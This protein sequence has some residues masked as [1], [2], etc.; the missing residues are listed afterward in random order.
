VKFAGARERDVR[1]MLFLPSF[2]TVEYADATQ[3]SVQARS[4]L[5]R[6]LIVQTT[7]AAQ[8]LE[9]GVRRVLADADP[10]IN[11]LRVLPLTLQVTGNFRI[12]RLVA[13]LLTIYG[14]LALALALLGLYGVTA[15]GVS[16]R[17]REIGVRMALGADRRGVVQTCVRGP[18]IQTA[19]GLAIGLVGAVFVGRAIATQLYG[20]AGFDVGVFAT[21]VITLLASALIAAALPARRAASVNPSAVLRGE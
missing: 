4:M 11:V 3:R 9:A 5:P 7:A 6:T 17:R 14:G 12:E 10:N 8:G 1:P 19:L 20:V 16:Q 21:A 2:Q 18:L 15:Y 13:R